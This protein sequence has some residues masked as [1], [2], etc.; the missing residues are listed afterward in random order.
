MEINNVVLRSDMYK[1]LARRI[2][3]LYEEIDALERIDEVLDDT[4]PE[5]GEYDD[6]VHDTLH[7]LLHTVPL[8]A[9]IDY[10]DYPYNVNAVEEGEEEEEAEPTFQGISR[11][12]YREWEGVSQK[13]ENGTGGALNPSE[14]DDDDETAHS[15]DIR[16]LCE[17][18]CKEALAAVD[19]A[20]AA[21]EGA[22]RAY[23]AK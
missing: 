21:L 9:H 18:Q 10:R 7:T 3:F 16:S 2:E 8:F 23:R 17:F 19:N 15:E 13:N 20:K 12:T 14:E 6:K 1:A 11:S 22:L 5:L 4:I